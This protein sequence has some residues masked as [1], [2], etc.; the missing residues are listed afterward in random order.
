MDEASRAGKKLLQ[1][2]VPEPELRP[3]QVTNQLD[4]AIPSLHDLDDPLLSAE[5]WPPD[6]Q[7]PEAIDPQVSDRG[8]LH[9][10]IREYPGFTQVLEKVVGE[11]RVGVGVSPEP[12]E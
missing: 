8:R 3:D 5:R 4:A 11:L 10:D 1:D 6:L 9:R 2:A 7:R 12:N